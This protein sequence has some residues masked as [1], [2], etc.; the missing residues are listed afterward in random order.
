MMM[1][2]S[3]S[4]RRVRPARQVAVA[5]DLPLP[6]GRVGDGRQGAAA[7]K[8]FQRRR[9]R[10]AALVVTV[11]DGAGR[12]DHRHADAQRPRFARP[13]RRELDPVADKDAFVGAVHTVTILAYLAV[14]SPL[15]C[16]AAPRAVLWVPR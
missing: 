1:L 11:A 15:T 2:L 8:R 13:A 16:S 14:T 5:P 10:A 7:G 4:I 12:P 3:R 6:L 9:H